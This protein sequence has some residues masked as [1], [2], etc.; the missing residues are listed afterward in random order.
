MEK[1]VIVSVVWMVATVLMLL[2]FQ[3]AV[4]RPLKRMVKAAEEETEACRVQHGFLNQQIE[5]LKDPYAEG[6]VFNRPVDESG[7]EVSRERF[8]NEPMNLHCK[9][10]GEQA[11]ITRMDVHRVV[12]DM[13]YKRH[14]MRA[15]FQPA[16]EQ[17]VAE[18]IAEG[19][20]VGEPVANEDGSVSLPVGL[21]GLED[22]V[23]GALKREC[24]PESYMV[25]IEEMA[26][27]LES[28]GKDVNGLSAS[29]TYAMYHEY[30]QEVIHKA[31]T[32]QC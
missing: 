7:R 3:L 6:S 23:A 5:D 28:K 30:R 29:K 17:F 18:K 16:T 31:K 15:K 9:A 2:V 1:A 10:C 20:Y 19:M 8:R 25:S 27:F 12:M 26:A 22:I 21:E 24:F 11:G 14:G 13:P 32:E 4:L